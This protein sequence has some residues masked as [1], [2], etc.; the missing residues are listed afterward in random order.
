MSNQVPEHS[1]DLEALRLISIN[2]LATLIGQSPRSVWKRLA[3]GALPEPIRIGRSVRW[4]LSDIKLFIDLDCDIRRY[5]AA[6]A[7]RMESQS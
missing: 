1:P 5:E 3:M 2:T 7:K 4:R 6:C